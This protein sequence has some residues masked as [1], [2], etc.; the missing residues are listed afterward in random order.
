MLY[1]VKDTSSASS[2]VAKNVISARFVHG[3]YW[4]NPAECTIMLIS[5]GDSMDSISELMRK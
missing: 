4:V 5:A 3:G 1:Y 2:F